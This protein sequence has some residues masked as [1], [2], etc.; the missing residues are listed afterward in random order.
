MMQAYRLAGEY[1]AALRKLSIGFQAPK[2]KTPDVE[3]EK[4]VSPSEPEQVGSPDLTRFKGQEKLVERVWFCGCQD[5][6]RPVRLAWLDALDFWLRRYKQTFGKV[7]M[8]FG[9]DAKN[10]VRICREHG[11]VTVR[12]LMANHFEQVEQWRRGGLTPVGHSITWFSG[13]LNQFASGPGEKP[14]DDEVQQTLLK[15]RAACC[16]A[17]GYSLNWLRIEKAQS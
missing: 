9:G 2:P 10:L 17:A 3:D 6:G 14:G 13:R 11:S 12:G 15:K 7:F 16:M 8:P 1:Q 5:D 4:S